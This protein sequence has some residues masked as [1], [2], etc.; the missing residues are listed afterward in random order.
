MMRKRARRSIMNVLAS[1]L[2]AMPA[3]AEL[4]LDAEEEVNAALTKWTRDFNAGKADA[5]CDLFSSDLKYDFRGY[6]ER[7]FADI[8]ARLKRS[9]T[10]SSRRYSYGL[11]I[12]EVIVEGNMAVV[13]LTWT[14]TVTLP[15]GQTVTSIE[16]G[17]DVMRRDANGKWKIVRYIAYEAPGRVTSDE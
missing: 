5:V 12:R 4:K 2:L 13:R 10:D 11:N 6:P 7:D 15:N 3:M 9:L 17:M 8:C 14:L 1:M 16:P